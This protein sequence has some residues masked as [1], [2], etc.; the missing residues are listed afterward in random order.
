[1]SSRPPF[2][3]ADVAEDLSACGLDLAS[4]ERSRY[5]G[6]EQ[7]PDDQSIDGKPDQQHQT[8]VQQTE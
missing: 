2:T 4:L 7:I 6:L 1:M 5:L 3:K 8:Y